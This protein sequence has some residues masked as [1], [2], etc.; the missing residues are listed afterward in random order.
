M[1]L[2]PTQGLSQSSPVSF[3]FTCHHLFFPRS[4]P[5]WE[6]SLGTWK[7]SLDTSRE[8]NIII[9]L[10]SVL[11]ICSSLFCICLDFARTARNMIYILL[12]LP[13]NTLEYFKS[14]YS[15]SLC[16]QKRTSPYYNHFPLAFF[17]KFLYSS[18]FSW[19]V[20]AEESEITKEKYNGR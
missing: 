8:I 10:F 1:G 20:V 11:S 3:H 7:I 18:P 15:I 14:C 9:P 2:Y 4:T 16:Y 19:A 13:S 6:V 12:C 5:S 17:G